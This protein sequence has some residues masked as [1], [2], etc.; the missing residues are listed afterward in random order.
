MRA[1]RNEVW[2]MFEN[3][4]IEHKIRVVPIIDNQVADYFPTTAGNFKTRIYSQKKYTIQVVNRPSIPDNSTYWYFFDD[5][6]HIKIFLE[7]SNEFVN[8]QIDTKNEN[9]EKF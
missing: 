1:Y 5:D 6:M 8:T 4:F 2:E 3:Y 9:L 7:L